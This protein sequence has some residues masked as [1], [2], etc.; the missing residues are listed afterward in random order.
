MRYTRYDYKKKKGGNFLIWLIFIIILAIGIG[1][2]LFK[3]LFSSDINPID[4]SKKDPSSQ[5]V[6]S[7]KEENKVFGIIQCGLYSTKEAAETAISTMPVV[8]PAFV[9]EEEGKFK[10]MA[11]VYEG[12]I[13]EKK[14]GELTSSSINNFRIKCDLPQNSMEKKAKVEVIDAYLKIINGLYEKDAESINT[15]ELKVWVDE[16]LNNVNEKDEEMSVLV[17][18]IKNLPAKY[19]KENV[20]ESMIF[21]YNLLIKYKA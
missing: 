18:N 8:F 13:L 14:M 5:S 7:T 1:M 6:P 9:V 3:I 15:D 2:G 16:L 10:I 11:G 20:K 17:E 21:M 12:D 4:T 19:K